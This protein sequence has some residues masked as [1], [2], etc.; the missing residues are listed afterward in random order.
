[1]RTEAEVEANLKHSSPL[2]QDRYTDHKR[3]MQR[4]GP[5]VKENIATAKRY[6]Q[7]LFAAHKDEGSLPGLTFT[8]SI[9]V[10]GGGRVSS[11][12]EGSVR[13]RFLGLPF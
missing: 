9:V 13:T 1:M 5:E 3:L 7:K 4:A 11:K 12:V 6:E 2:L 8:W 10:T